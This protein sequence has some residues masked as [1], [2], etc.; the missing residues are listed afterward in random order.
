MK[1]NGGEKWIADYHDRTVFVV[2]ADRSHHGY[3]S[4]S[5][6][7]GILSLEQIGN[8]SYE[9]AMHLLHIWT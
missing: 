8:Q 6:N 5:S 4:T 1:M 3:V 2:E 9:G 7:Y